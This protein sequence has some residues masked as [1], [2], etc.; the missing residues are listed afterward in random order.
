MSRFVRIQ[1]SVYLVH[2]RWIADSAAAGKSP[3]NTHREQSCSERTAEHLDFSSVVQH[4][5]ISLV[6]LNYNAVH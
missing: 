6:T 2:N 1:S 3:I 5:S 4:V